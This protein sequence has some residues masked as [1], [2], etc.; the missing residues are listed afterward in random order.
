MK[1]LADQPCPEVTEQRTEKLLDALRVAHDAHLRIVQ[2]KQAPDA[3]VE[4]ARI[5]WDELHKM[6][7]IWQAEYTHEQW[8]AHRYYWRATGEHLEEMYARA[9]K[10]EALDD[11]KK[12][13]EIIDFAQAQRKAWAA[14][15][16]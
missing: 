9:D 16:S 6:A 11:S 7:D 1:Y 15:E 14:N 8:W 12:K 3:V 2:N 13:G 10:E 4:E 5:I